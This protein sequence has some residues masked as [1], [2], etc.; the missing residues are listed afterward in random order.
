[1]SSR[2]LLIEVRFVDGRYHGNRDWPPSPF[3]LFQALVAGS[4]GGRWA[5]ESATDKDEAL[6]WLE[7]L[8]APHV[9]A[10]PMRE[11]TRI[12][13]YVPN[14]DLDAKAGDPLRVDEIWVKKRIA[15][16]LFDCEVPILYAWPFD[17][18]EEHALT[19]ARLA[20]RLHT[21][22]L[23]FDAAFARGETA[24]WEAAEMRLVAH[25]GA[26]ARP[27][28][29]IVDG[30]TCPTAGSLN[31]L[32]ARHRDLAKRFR[33]EGK[34]VLYANAAKPR[35]RQIAYDS[36]PTRLLFDL[37]G[38]TAVWPLIR[39]VELTERMRDAVAERL[40]TALRG[41]A[42]TV[43]NTIVGLRASDE[44][45]QG[46]ACAHHTSPVHWTSARRPRD[47]ARTG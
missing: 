20:E 1:M 29:P 33:R 17:E 36:S 4:Y 15:P 23:G 35:F 18:G 31:S 25:R 16:R 26:V 44:F 45:R 7:R 24:A 22:G 19:V 6:R 3:R 38:A 9:A 41:Q 30:S 32:K 13:L 8:D 39:I 46:G 37:A 11:V 47:P 10:P 42:N 40:K 2:A 28:G 14:N 5:S 34:G 27:S 21:L 43:H 12:S